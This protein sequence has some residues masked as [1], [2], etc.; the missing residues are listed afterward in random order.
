MVQEDFQK[1]A[2][3]YASLTENKV[4]VK[5]G[6]SQVQTI[7]TLVHEIAHA[8]CHQP[9]AFLEEQTPAQKRQNE[10]EAESWINYS[11]WRHSPV[12]G[13]KNRKER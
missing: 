10:I 3:G 9:G 4:V 7:K 1:I 11:V 2:Y 8:K 12:L 6:L 5:P 13:R